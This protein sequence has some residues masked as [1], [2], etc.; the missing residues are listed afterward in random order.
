MNELIKAT[1]N[2]E[3]RFVRKGLPLSEIIAGEKPCGGHGKCGKC[4]V[5]AKGTLSSPSEA[6]RELLTKEELE[7]GI[8][9]S[10]CTIAEGSCE[11]ISLTKSAEA[12]IL[13]DGR[14]AEIELDPIFT[15]YGA[16][17]DVGTTTLAARLYDRC[18]NVIASASRLNPQSCFGD[19]VISRIE[20]AL[21]GKRDELAFLIRNSLDGM[22]SELAS[23]AKIDTQNIDAVTVTGNTVMLSFLVCE[24]VT[25]FSRAPFKAKRLFDEEVKAKT[26]GFTSLAPDTPI[27]LP[28]CISAFVGA[29]T[30]CA[31]LATELDKK[32]TAMLVDIG[33]N[34]EMAILYGGKLTVT[35]TAAGPAFEGVGISMGMRGAVGA[36]DKVTLVNGKPYVHV[37][38]EGRATGICGSGLVDAVSCM[39]D[40]ETVD[41]TG[42]LD[43][44]PFTLCEGV[45]IT[46]AD[47]RKLQLAKSAI[48][49]GLVTLVENAGIDPEDVT[50]LY[51]AGGFGNYLNKK[52]AQRIG[53]LPKK[54]AER[55]ETVGN[56]ALEGAG[57]LL[58]D[59]SMRKKAVKLAE[60][61]EALELSTHKGFS[62]H[63]IM[64]M[65]FE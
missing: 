6:E 15:Q 25:P 45:S 38:G 5:L 48:C 61:A 57:M 3:L 30:V 24:D 27:Y 53:L 41:E 64:G 23:V 10:C 39:L 16:A 26:L 54:L 31:L 46:G 32:G 18:G 33:T 19:D 12:Q 1:V 22:L 42:A 8:R 28:P 35:S 44:D 55:S 13:T 50:V 58:L 60:R 51:I 17:I 63:F 59:A 47:I 11:I 7:S 65:M 34:G 21:G 43:D 36:V 49:A 20:A 40:C 29:D 52:S 14:R 9:L 4:R 37:I 56:A 62:E 2:G